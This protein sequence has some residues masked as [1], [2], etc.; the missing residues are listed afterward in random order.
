MAKNVTS[1][2]RR[3]SRRA[4]RKVTLTT[5]L[6]MGSLVAFV[7]FYSGQDKRA[8]PESTLDIELQRCLQVHDENESVVVDYPVTKLSVGFHDL[9]CARLLPMLGIN[10]PPPHFIDKRSLF[11]WVFLS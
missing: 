9:S 6:H 10:T 8:H 4:K 7:T 2:T 11:L 3:E 1:Y 5:A